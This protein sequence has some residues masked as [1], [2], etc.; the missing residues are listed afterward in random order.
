MKHLLLLA[1]LFS[2]QAYSAELLECQS[3]GHNPSYDLSISNDLGGG[4]MRLSLHRL[5]T[6]FV[7]SPNDRVHLGKD[8]IQLRLNPSTCMVE[9]TS[10]ENSRTEFRVNLD[11]RSNRLNGRINGSAISPFEGHNISQ[12]LMCTPSNSQLVM[13]LRDV[14]D[15]YASRDE[16]MIFTRTMQ[17]IEALD[18]VSPMMDSDVE[19]DV[20]LEIFDGSS[21]GSRGQQG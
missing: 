15:N 3:D 19:E 4:Q 13:S 21:N 6:G 1:A 7:A 10:L 17:I 8:P 2:L 9:I 18:R 5:M 11:L 20:D 12:G 16:D 14:C